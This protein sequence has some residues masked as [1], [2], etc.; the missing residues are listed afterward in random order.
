MV[1]NVLS[2]DGDIAVVGIDAGGV[3]VGGERVSS[4][5]E[6][7][8]D[9]SVAQIH[10]A[11]IGVGYVIG[12]QI[13][14][15]A[16]GEVS[17]IAVGISTAGNAVASR[18]NGAQQVA[19]GE[20]RAN[21][22]SGF[23]AEVIDVG[24]SRILGRGVTTGV[25][26][27]VSLPL[28]MGEGVTSDNRCSGDGEGEAV[29]GLVTVGDQDRVGQILQNAG[30][31]RA[32]VTDLSAATDVGNASIHHQ[33]GV[34]QAGERQGDGTS[35]EL[36]FHDVI[37]QGK[38]LVRLPRYSGDGLSKAWSVPVLK[39]IIKT[40]GCDFRLVV[41]NDGHGGF[42]KISDNFDAGA[43][44]CISVKLGGV[45]LM[46]ELGLGGLD[47]GSRLRLCAISFFGLISCWCGDVQQ[48]LLPLISFHALLGGACLL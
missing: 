45:R 17:G 1:I 26:V 33:A 31:D 18:G 12:G 41:A 22:H 9:K 6:G 36:Q 16:I 23:N 5:H 28:G 13:P 3:T 47:A 11:G 48:V 37:L 30:S 14:S 44:E 40:I 46:C 2:Q 27:G 29:G 35:D 39:N 43:L 15:G 42:V 19:I 21:F 25:G 34:G 24:A 38:F 20:G 8:D 4:G 10:E 7:H 32:V